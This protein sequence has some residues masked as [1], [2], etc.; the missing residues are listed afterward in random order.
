MFGRPAA[1]A[2][3][4]CAL[5]VPDNAHHSCSLPRLPPLQLPEELEVARVSAS[6]VAAVQAETES[7][8]GAEGAAPSR[9]LV[10]LPPTFYA[11]RRV[12]GGSFYRAGGL[13]FC[14]DSLQFLPSIV[15]SQYLMALSGG[16][17]H[18]L[19]T[20]DAKSATAGYAVLLFILP[21]L[22]TLVEQAYFY[23]VQCINMSVKA[24]LTTAV[25]QKSTRL[26]LAAKTASNSGE[27]LNLMQLDASRIGE[28]MTYLHVLWSAFL[29]S[30]GY[31]AS[32]SIPV[33]P[34]TTS[35]PN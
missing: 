17:A 31:L 20:P 9:R 28:L 22:K 7:G 26:S 24:A 15:L 18:N 13:K 1:V 29:Q 10:D 27:V 35:D 16:K 12:F 2:C 32:A 11:L 25:Y 5:E 3:C 21:V 30:V 14:S 33:P 4:V 6:F 19:S 34:G 8:R 23:R